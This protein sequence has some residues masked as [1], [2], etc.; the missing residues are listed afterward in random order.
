MLIKRTINEIMHVLQTAN[1]KA[2][3]AMYAQVT[4]YAINLSRKAAG[5]AL[6]QTDQAMTKPVLMTMEDKN[7]NQTT[8]LIAFYH[9]YQQF[10][11]ELP[12]NSKYTNTQHTITGNHYY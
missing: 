3:Y 4:V 12:Q 2:C 7:K 9:L 6:A 8:T 11:V 10:F 1:H 5:Y